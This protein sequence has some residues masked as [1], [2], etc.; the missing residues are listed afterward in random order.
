MNCKQLIVS[1]E[2]VFLN[3]RHLTQLLKVNGWQ[4]LLL[5]LKCLAVLLHDTFKPD[6]APRLECG[7]W[8][9]KVEFA[10]RR[11]LNLD[12]HLGLRSVPG[13]VT[14]RHG[15]IIATN[16]LRCGRWHERHLSLFLILLMQLQALLA[17]AICHRLITQLVE[18]HRFILIAE[19]GFT[20][21]PT[22]ELELIGFLLID[23]A[24]IHFVLLNIHFKGEAS[25]SN[26]R[27]GAVCDHELLPIELFFAFLYGHS[28]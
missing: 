4:W 2:Q 7:L 28:L 8:A 21:I 10:L 22:V 19:F 3:W 6:H 20:K 5:S 18:A 24:T 23:L 26:C 25:V 11:L 12:V 9:R 17:E 14:S 15:L 16:F 13:L 27:G 1:I